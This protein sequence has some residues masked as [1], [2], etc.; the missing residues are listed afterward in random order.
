MKLLRNKIYEQEFRIHLTFYVIIVIIP[1]VILYNLV[2]DIPLFQSI[3]YD[4]GIQ[5]VNSILTLS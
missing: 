1:R 5:N 4:P 3:L 2:S